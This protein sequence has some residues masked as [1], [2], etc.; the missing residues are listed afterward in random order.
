MPLAS[1]KRPLLVKGKNTC[2]PTQLPLIIPDVP[3]STILSVAASSQAIQML[4]HGIWLISEYMQQFMMLWDLIFIILSLLQDA[5]QCLCG[6]A[7]DRCE[8]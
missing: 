3:H 2:N 1:F 7:C 8:I 5:S 4:F 6:P